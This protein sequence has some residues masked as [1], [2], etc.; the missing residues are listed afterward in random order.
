MTLLMHEPTAA[1]LRSKVDS[2]GQRQ[3]TAIRSHAAEGSERLAATRPCSEMVRA[4]PR[5]EWWSH[6]RSRRRPF[7]LM[8]GLG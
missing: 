6:W 3:L 7:F 2:G 4:D 5:E 8:K 1:V